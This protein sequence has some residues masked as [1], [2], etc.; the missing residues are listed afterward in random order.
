MRVGRPVE[1]GDALVMPTSGTT[2]QPR[3]AVLTHDAVRA[4]ARA[5]S[6]R[7]GVGP[8][9]SWLSMLPLSHVGG[10]SVII[11]SLVTG[12]PL[13]FEGEATLTSMVPTQLLRSDPSRFR[14]VLLGGQ[15]PPA[16]LPPNIVVTYGMTETGSGVVYDGAPLDGVEVRVEDGRIFVR[17]PMLLRCYRDGADPKDAGGWLDTGDGGRIE[18]GRLHVD[19]RLSDL[20]VTGGENVWP[21]PVEA[22]LREH[23]QVADVAVVGRTDPEWGQRVTAVVVPA[24]EPPTLDG[25][26]AFVKERL[27]AYAAP[28]ELVLTDRLERTALGKLR[29]SGLQN[30]R[31]NA[32]FAGEND[33]E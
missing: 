33:Q 20:I 23:P 22:I 17:G 10:L 11:R 29:R 3:G 4:S 27:P 19:G 25:L 32:G 12:T 9:D 15:A 24:G 18:G 8:G 28:K 1:E 14:A 30:P 13:V 26:R 2:G 16:D 21:A 7:L 6:A 5:S 31:H